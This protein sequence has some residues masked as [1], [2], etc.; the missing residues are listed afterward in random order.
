M[1]LICS[2]VGSTRHKGAHCA[3]RDTTMSDDESLDWHV[4]DCPSGAP[5]TSPEKL[6][7][8]LVEDDAST[9][10]GESFATLE[11]E[12]QSSCGKGS[13]SGSGKQSLPC[14][15]CFRTKCVHKDFM[16]PGADF[17]WDNSNN[18]CRFCNDCLGG[19]RTCHSLSHSLTLFAG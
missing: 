2:L 9:A 12:S 10:A 7:I 13:T 19:W 5:S 15:G 18:T 17:E 8:A 14:L 16:D 4:I 3:D 6:A 11:V 1:H